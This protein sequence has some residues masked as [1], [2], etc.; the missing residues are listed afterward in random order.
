ML[1]EYVTPL[2]VG[3]TK[4]V[5]VGNLV[6]NFFDTGE[7]SRGAAAAL[8]IAAFVVAILVVFRRSLDLAG[9]ERA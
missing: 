3:G 4:G 1:G 9:G 5:M 2:L 8:L 7:Y 6:A